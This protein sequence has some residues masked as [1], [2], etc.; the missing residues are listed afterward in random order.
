MKA[1]IDYLEACGSISSDSVAYNLPDK[2]CPPFTF[3]RKEFDAY[4][5][6]IC[7]DAGDL[8]QWFIE[9]AYFPTSVIPFHFEGKEYRLVI[10]SGQGTIDTL[11]TIPECEGWMARML[12]LDQEGFDDEEI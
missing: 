10:M 5:K 2:G 9:E 12:A 4:V 6:Q 7:K 1:I 3:T 8:D 11:C